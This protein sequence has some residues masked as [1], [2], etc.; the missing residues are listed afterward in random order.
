MKRWGIWGLWALL[1]PM[2]A[3]WACGMNTHTKPFVLA[4]GATPSDAPV[5]TLRAPELR[6]IEVTRGLGGAEGMCDGQGLLGIRLTWPRGDYDLNQVGFEFRV[7][8]MDSPYTVF[9]AEPVAA[10]SDTRR[11]DMLFF[12]PDDAPGQQK[13]LRMEVEVRAV[14]RNYQRGPATRLVIDSTDL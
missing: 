5:D 10:V 7:V 3:A 14:T 8:A 13:P 11:A 1:L 12:F 4:E 6:V 2:Q 9:P